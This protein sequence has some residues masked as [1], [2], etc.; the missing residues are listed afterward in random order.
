MQML[1]R[2]LLV[3]YSYKKVPLQAFDFVLLPVLDYFFIPLFCGKGFICMY[4]HLGYAFTSTHTR[5][6]GHGSSN[7]YNTFICMF[8][9]S[10]CDAMGLQQSWPLAKTVAH[11]SA[12]LSEESI[13]GL[14][15]VSVTAAWTCNVLRGYVTPLAS[16]F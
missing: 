1:P 10:L 15:D 14:L 8:A 3:L 4:A 11:L 6:L 5:M 13:E 9:F 12:E 7:G 2:F 16:F